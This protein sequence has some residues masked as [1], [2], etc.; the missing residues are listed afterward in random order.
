MYALLI[1]LYARLH[2]ACVDNTFDEEIVSSED[3]QI[4][5]IQHCH[6]AA[7]DDND[8]YRSQRYY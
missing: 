2:P 5:V 1:F 4:L 7:I 8:G 6:S 3:K